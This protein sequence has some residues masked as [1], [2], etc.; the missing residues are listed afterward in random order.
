VT[1]FEITFVP[2]RGKGP[3]IAYQ[4]SALSRMDAVRRARQMVDIEAP[5]SKLHQSREIS[6]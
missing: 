3:A 1:T 5:G 4:L 6:L 2:A